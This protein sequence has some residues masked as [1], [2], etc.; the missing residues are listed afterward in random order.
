MAKKL[1]YVQIA[2]RSGLSVMSVSNVLRRPD[3]VREET[4]RRVHEAIRSLGGELPQSAQAGAKP[5]VMPRPHRRLR[6]ITAAIP[7]ALRESQVYSRLFQATIR[8]ANSADY[9]LSFT[10]LD[11]ATDLNERRF[12]DGYDA[13][14]I[15]GDWS[16][17]RTAP[18]LPVISVMSTTA[19]FPTDHIGYNR[20]GVGSIV[21]RYFLECGLRN[22]AYIGSDDPDRYRSFLSAMKTGGGKSAKELV[23]S[24]YRIAGGTQSIDMQELSVVVD[25]VLRGGSRPEGVFTHTDQMAVALRKVFAD[26]GVLFEPDRIVGCNNDPAWMDMLGAGAVSIELGVADIGKLAVVR[27]VE[28]AKG[29]TLLKSRM[30]LEPC[31]VFREQ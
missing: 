16:S 9:D 28:A 23:A 11:A 24:P 3:G 19:G 17:V 15:M 30:L 7:L 2:E 20:E 22:V 5:L 27:A 29:G 25:K 12:V 14:I 21:A 10:N 1:T 18:S 31:L 6:F 13:L 26:K 8:E 4:R